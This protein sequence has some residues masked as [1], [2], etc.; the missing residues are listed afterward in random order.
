MAI[1]VPSLEALG[2]AIR[3]AHHVEAGELV[4]QLLRD[5]YPLPE[6]IKY[7][8]ETEAPYVHV[9]SHI[10]EREAELVGVQYDHTILGLRA[11]WRV[12]PYMPSPFEHLPWVQAI[13]YMP[14]GMDICGQLIGTFPG[15]YARQKGYEV[16]PDKRAE[17][18]LYFPDIFEP[19]R[20][21]TLD[22]RLRAMFKLTVDGE[23]V[24]AWQ[25]FLGLVQDAIADPSL[26]P[27]I[28]HHVLYAALIDKEESCIG[29]AM[30]SQ[31]GHKALR[32]RSMFDL[33]DWFGWANAHAAFYT[34]F[35]DLPTSPRYYQMYDI[36][37]STLKFELKDAAATLHERNTTPL[38]DAEIDDLV[39]VIHGDDRWAVARAI[40]ERLQAGTSIQSIAD[41]IFVASAEYM[42]K[43]ENP[44]AYFLPYHAYDYCNVATSWMRAGL[45]RNS[46]KVLYLMAQSV[47]AAA[48]HVRQ[49]GSA[50][51]YIIEPLPIPSNW[52]N[53][54]VCGEVFD[55]I[56]G[57]D[58]RRVTGLVATYLAEQRDH[59]ALITTFSHAAGIYEGDPHVMRDAASSIEEY[60]HNSTGRQERILLYWGKY[61]SH[62]QKRTLDQDCYQ[63]YRR[64]LVDV[65]RP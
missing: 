61:L 4:C 14:Q 50:E 29:Q 41:A 32:T 47:H 28:R 1:A 49:F 27:I 55:G 60:E 58:D 51:S 3:D 13:W 31:Q 59:R 18:E 34:G 23:R 45:D 24:R 30:T 25:Y 56:I 35:P 38:S 26:Q 54:R 53:E 42:L 65:E 62:A 22:E 12:A 37:T 19:I 43:L 33:A 8:M 57:R 9:P 6:L 17:P 40:T 7:C 16:T 2:Q 10:I 63:T 36:A 39:A 44:K 15:H 20:A 52:T 48:Q 64:Y 46:A 5:G 11:G 21:G